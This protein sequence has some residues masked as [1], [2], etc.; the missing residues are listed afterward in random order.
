MGEWRLE[1]LLDSELES[2]NFKSFDEASS[3]FRSLIG[4]YGERLHRA[5]LIDPAGQRQL[6]DIP[7][8]LA[9]QVIEMETREA[10]FESG[11]SEEPAI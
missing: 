5:F 9:Q 3:V 4:D 8:P 10:S 2:C 6:L 1:I 11:F 7:P